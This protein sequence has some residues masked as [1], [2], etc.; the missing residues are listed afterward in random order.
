M[1]I[2]IRDP[3]VIENMVCLSTEVFMVNMCWYSLPL[4]VASTGVEMFGSSN[5]RPWSSSV[6]FNHFNNIE[7]FCFSRDVERTGYDSINV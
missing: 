1:T 4:K 6:P 2:F 5:M 3:S 7:L